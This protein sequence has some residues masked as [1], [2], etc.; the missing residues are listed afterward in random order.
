MPTRRTKSGAR[1]VAALAGRAEREGLKRETLSQ[2]VEAASE[3]GATL[4]LSRLGL[5]DEDAGHDIRA[6]RD[7]LDSWRRAKRTAWHSII[8]WA[9]T[10]FILLLLAALAIKVKIPILNL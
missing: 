3:H 4:A 8:R 6:L 1:A 10:L 2:L 7:L 5:H 9:I